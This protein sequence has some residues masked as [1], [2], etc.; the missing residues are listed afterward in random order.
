MMILRE[1]S[2]NE[3]K[4]KLPEFYWD[5]K[6]YA[7]PLIKF[8]EDNK[9]MFYMIEEET[10]TYAKQLVNDAKTIIGYSPVAY[11]TVT[12]FESSKGHNI[13]FE[14]LIDSLNKI[15]EWEIKK[16]KYPNTIEI[17]HNIKSGSQEFLTAYI[18]EIED[19]AMLVSL[20]N[21]KGFQI[22]AFS[23]GEYTNGQPFGITWG[24]Q[25]NSLKGITQDELTRFK[26][27][28]SNELCREAISS[29]Q[30]IYSQISNSSKLT[31]CW[32]TIEHIF[33]EKPK[34]ILEK[35]EIGE[36]IEL[37]KS[38]NLSEVKIKKIEEIIKNPNL[39][40]EKNRNVRIAENM[41]Q[42]LGLNQEQTYNEI[43]NMT[44]TRGMMVHS[45]GN[46][47]DISNHLTFVEGILSSYIGKLSGIE[48]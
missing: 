3:V 45:L 36:V 11:C 26:N 41:S 46:E 18:N 6:V 10:I 33:D 37:M 21:K 32:A 23:Q 13:L 4:E 30:L 8:S 14:D 20:K 15:T 24:L 12:S 17:R 1:I 19:V 39:L 9:L 25:Q 22:S 28:L 40:A 5:K 44:K 42:T 34:H 2:Q 29:L 27:I 43:R 47:T 38:S 16:S 35:K 48:I 31:I 7:L